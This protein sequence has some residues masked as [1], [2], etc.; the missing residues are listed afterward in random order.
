MTPLR[1]KT[2]NNEVVG[3]YSLAPQDLELSVHS[4]DWGPTVLGPTV[5]GPTV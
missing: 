2:L 5:W 3:A 4:L 1:Q